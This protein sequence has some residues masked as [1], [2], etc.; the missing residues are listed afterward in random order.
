MDKIKPIVGILYETFLE[1]SETI[2]FNGYKSICRNRKKRRG[3][4]LAILIREDWV[5][6]VIEITEQEEKKQKCLWLEF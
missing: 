3:G 6:R 1:E 5:K 4:G 2:H